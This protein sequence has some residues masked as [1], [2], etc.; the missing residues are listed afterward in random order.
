MSPLY[1][2]YAWLLDPERPWPAVCFLYFLLTF[3]VSGALEDW[4]WFAWGV[5]L[6][7]LA[8]GAV[9]LAVSAM[10][11]FTRFIVRLLM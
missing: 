4:R 2:A 8:G 5:A 9:F 7:I 3:C 11:I 10:L 6:P 1:R